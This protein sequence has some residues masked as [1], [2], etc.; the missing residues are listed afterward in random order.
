MDEISISTSLTTVSRSDCEVVIAAV[1]RDLARLASEADASRAAQVL[2]GVYRTDA[3]SNPTIYANT[4]ASLLSRYPVRVVRRVVDPVDGL[5]GSL[6]FLPSI[7]EIKAA[8]EMERKKLANRGFKARWMLQKHAEADAEAQR[9]AQMTDAERAEQLRR[10]DEIVGQFRK[11]KA[12][13]AA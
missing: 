1:D 12:E 5:P 11:P 7:A 10:I 4:V 13:D 3:V 8:L 2:L 9:Q 6:K